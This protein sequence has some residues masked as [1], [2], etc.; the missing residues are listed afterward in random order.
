ML[1][2]SGAGGDV[3]HD[4]TIDPRP[5]VNGLPSIRLPC[6]IQ[7][8]DRRLPFAKHAGCSSTIH[9]YQSFTPVPR[10]DGALHRFGG[11]V[12]YHGLGGRSTTPSMRRYCR[13]LQ[14]LRRPAAA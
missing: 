13:Q 14:R 1:G 10:G 3:T 8:L 7:A 6:A 11:R 2:L 9:G 5:S 12:L 4:F